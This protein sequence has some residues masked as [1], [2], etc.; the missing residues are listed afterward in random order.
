M[1]KIFK[2]ILAIFAVFII[3]VI[4]FAGIIFLDLAALFAT[5]SEPLSPTGSVM[6]KA[7]VVYDPGLSGAAK[8]VANKIAL[9]LQDN[10]YAVTFA[11]IKSSIANSPLYGFNIIVVGGPIYAGTPT[12]SVKD[13]LSNL[14]AV[15]GGA[16]I[17]VFGSGSGPQEQS[18]ITQIKNFIA[19]LPNSSSLS[20]AI[21]VKIGSGEDINAR[22]ADFVNQLIP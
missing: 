5:G 19:G 15:Q 11:G 6:G 12:S 1:R 7:L 16:T 14:N 18:D 17:G 22:S 10:G 21:V 8:D 13:F 4:L 3:G 2:I 20:D 9:N